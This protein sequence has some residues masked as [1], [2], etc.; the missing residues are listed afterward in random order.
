MIFYCVHELEYINKFKD[1]E[2][3][4]N[5]LSYSELYKYPNF[6]RAYKW[7]EHKM[8]QRLKNYDGE[9]LLWLW[10]TLPEEISDF[11]EW[12]IGK[13]FVTLKVDI[14][15][16]DVLLSD[17]IAWHY[18]LN[19]APIKFYEGE[20]IKKKPS[21]ERIFDFKLLKRYG[22]YITDSNDIQGTTGKI[23][24]KNVEIIRYQTITKEDYD[25]QD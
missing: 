12:D 21:W 11:N 6:A 18:I 4:E 25:G 15:E 23:P 3:L 10:T 13:T 8:R 1:K 20:N 14:P 2:Y 5:D 19:N 16:E 9:N 24:M 22:S 7:M 17:F